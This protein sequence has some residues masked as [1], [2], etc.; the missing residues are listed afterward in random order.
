MTLSGDGSGIADA[1]C[2]AADFLVR[3]RTAQDVAVSDRAVDLT[4]LVVSELVTNALKHAPGPAVLE[5]RLTGDAV[6]V[7]VRDTVRVLPA[8]GAVDPERVG[9]HGLEIV[10]ALA[11]EFHVGL[12]PSGKRV[13]ARIPLSDPSDLSGSS[14]SDVSNSRPGSTRP[15]PTA[16][17]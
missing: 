17:S 10:R 3:A 9:G 2:F 16:P 7:T 13:T 14:G 8:V 1:R 15:R 11:E 5:L 12:E 6:E 4:R